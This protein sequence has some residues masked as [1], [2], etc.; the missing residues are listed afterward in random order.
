VIEGSEDGS[1]FGAFVA[2]SADGATTIIGAPIFGE[3]FI[4][5][6]PVQT[7]I[8]PIWVRQASLSSATSDQFSNFGAAVAISG[9][10]SIA[11]VGAST[12][13]LVYVFTRSSGW[14]VQQFLTPHTEQRIAFGSSVALTAAGTI[15]LIAAPEENDFTGAAYAYTN[16]GTTWTLQARLSAPATGAGA[17]T[18]LDQF[19]YSESL[20]PDGSTALVGAVSKTIGSNARQGAAYSFTRSGNSWALAHFLTAPTS[21][22]NAGATDDHFGNS[23]ALSNQGQTALIGAF[24]K[25]IGTNGQQG[26]AYVVIPSPLAVVIGTLTNLI[27]NSNLP[28]PAQTALL[29][30]VQ[31][32]SLLESS[33][34]A[35]PGVAALQFLIGRV[36][37]MQSLKLIT[38]PQADQLLGVANQAITD[39]VSQ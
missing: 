11:L 39:L 29:N 38:G 8:G 21:G 28:A 15:A 32:L 26:V 36:K 9:D 19:G 13:D 27:N 4:Y 30:T 34:D 5:S 18:G 22:P 31:R 35:Q 37:Q 6:G 17:S 14:A 16:D 12:D 2:L 24:S 1:S 20:S 25:T 33:S 7:S 23:V 10:G 3:A